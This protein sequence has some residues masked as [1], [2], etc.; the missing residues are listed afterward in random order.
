[1]TLYQPGTHDWIRMLAC[2]PCTAQLRAGPL[3]PGIARVTEVRNEEVV[4]S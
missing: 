3:S 1:V 4:G 2:V